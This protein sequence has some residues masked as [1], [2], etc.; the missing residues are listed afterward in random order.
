MVYPVQPAPRGGFPAERASRRGPIVLAVFLLI[1]GVAF[2]TIG[3]NMLAQS[4]SAARRPTTPGTILTSGL[5]QHRG[6]KGSVSWSVEV[7]YSYQVGNAHFVGDRLA[8]LR[9]R[10][11]HSSASQD[12]RALSP[13]TACT[14]YYDP[15]DP[16]N[17]VL[18]PSPGPVPYVLAAGGAIGLLAGLACFLAWWYKRG[19]PPA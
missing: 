5:Q 12:L 18:R 13:G 7:T 17:A 3:G 19:A 11:S 15:E 8:M 9:S 14:V 4:W 6:S 2:A 16:Q 1:L 10:G